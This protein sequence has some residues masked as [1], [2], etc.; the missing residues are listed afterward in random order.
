VTY[1]GSTPVFAIT[2]TSGSLKLSAGT[3]FTINLISPLSLGTYHLITSGVSGVAPAAVSIP[4]RVAH[5]AITG[6]G[7]LDLVV[8]SSTEP[9]QP[10]H[11]AGPGAGL[12]QVLTPTNVWKDS[13]VSPV[14][15]YFTGG[16][17]VQFDEQFISADQVVT[18]NSTVTP[19]STVVSNVT[20]SY[21]ISGTGTIGGTGGLTK[22]GAGTL[23]LSVTGAFTGGTVLANGT[24]MLGNAK[25]LGASGGTVTV[26]SGAVLDVN[27]TM[28]TSANP[29]A[30]TLNGSG[31]AGAGVLI[32]SST[33]QATNY[34]SIVLATNSTINAIGATLTLGDSSHTMPITGSYPLTVRATLNNL[35]RIYGN[36]QADSVTKLDA[37]IIRLESANSFAGGLTVKAGSVTAKNASSLGGDGSGTVYLLDTTGGDNV[38]LDLGMNST[39]N[40]SLIVQAGSTGVATV[41]DYLNYSPTWAG[42]IT[43]NSDL[44]LQ[45]SSGQTLAVTG[46]I[47][48]S[49]GLRITSWNTNCQVN[50]SGDN[51][52]SGDTYVTIGTL[53]LT[54]A[55]S[56]PN[57][58]R[59]SV[60]GGATFDVSTL[61]SGTFTLGSG[62]TLA[63][64]LGTNLTGNL[65]G[66]I[67]ASSGEMLVTYNGIT[68]VFNVSS[69]LLTLSAATAF[70][71]NPTSVLP[72][73]TY[74]LIASG[75]SGSAPATVTMLRGSGYLLIN[76][77]GGLDLV[78]TSTTTGVTDPLH[79][80]G[81]GS[82]LWQVATP[83]NVWKDSSLAAMFTSYADAAP[84]QFDEK[85]IAADQVVTVNATV[86]PPS[87][88]VSNAVHNYTISGPGAIVGACG[89]TKLGSGTFTLATF[90][91][92]TGST[93]VSNG[94][95]LLNGSINSPVIVNGG[96]LGG[97]GFI[98]GS[99]TVNNGGTLAPGTNGVYRL[100]ITNNLTL[101]SGAT[102]SFAVTGGVPSMN[103]VQAG[104]QVT[105]GGTLNIVP[106]G[107]FHLGDQ[108]Q[109]FTGSGVTSTSSFASI[110]GS[111]GSGLAFSFTNGW[112]SVV[113]AGPSAPAY[114]TNSYNGGVLT[115]SWP[116]GQGWLL[117]SNSVSLSNTGAWQ[118]VTGATP[119][120]PIT[121]RPSQSAVFYRLKY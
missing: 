114:L 20:H 72:L 108:Y 41:D 8:D 81:T 44:N 104:G 71:V 54:G 29:Y 74:N 99:V 24:L 25:A 16:D 14:Y 19:A 31:I 105:Y 40:N 86:I 39:F 89:L 65:N 33:T 52:Y 107:T 63:N 28:M 17:Q 109:L 36:V 112:L 7:G 6:G 56:L 55:G 9:T 113:A 32:N 30:L 57:S 62:Q 69:G 10:L 58:S 83:T 100:M 76:G 120:Y 18:L 98:N 78:V 119:P 1:D 13:S 103:W 75:V 97:V 59:I 102:S 61:N 49:G 118:T 47:S 4:R 34:G 12:W 80:A 70:T 95:L 93:V 37:G 88:L 35:V 77:G 115:L 84:V 96:T 23:N 3:V 82:G 116:T 85:F 60:A 51:T 27:G 67:D 50:L 46:P 15:S 42:S 91:T 92:Y 5:L 26:N 48:G 87:V 106:T 79:W 110:L 68:P 45:G 111:P 64:S 73:G 101:N 94:I 21:T 66:N 43:L 117:Q 38:T 2:T 90:N 22:N 11:W 53:A 121:N